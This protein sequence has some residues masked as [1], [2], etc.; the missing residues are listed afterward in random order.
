MSDTTDYRAVNKQL[1]AECDFKIIGKRMQSVRK[2]R[3]MTQAEIAEKMKLGTKY[4][5]S[6]EAGAAK[7]SFP[8][9][10][11]FIIIMQSSADYLLSGCHPEYPTQFAC[12]DEACKERVLLNKLL[13]QC[14]D[15]L[16]RTI[17]V[18]A[19]GL[20]ASNNK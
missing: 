16:I 18:V 11:Q 19:Q 4:Y 14:P 13:D 1:K 8:R 5:A 15:D 9:F 10:L 3:G 6:M 20:I 17:Y 12:P 2:E 7:I